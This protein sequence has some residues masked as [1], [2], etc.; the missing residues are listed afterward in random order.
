[1][2][3]GEEKAVR[4]VVKTAF[5]MTLGTSKWNFLVNLLP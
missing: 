1:M 3:R 2:D 5:K 4:I